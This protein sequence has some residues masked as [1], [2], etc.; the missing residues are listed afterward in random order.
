[1]AKASSKDLIY[2][3]GKSLRAYPAFEF[4]LESPSTPTI[5]DFENYEF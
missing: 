1:L 2:C 3:F 5:D 4:A